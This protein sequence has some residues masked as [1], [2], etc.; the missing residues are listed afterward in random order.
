MSTMRSLDDGKVK[1]AI[2]FADGLEVG[3]LSWVIDSHH[4]FMVLAN[5]GKLIIGQTRGCGPRCEAFQYGTHRVN[6]FNIVNRK[7]YDSPPTIGD[8][9][10]QPLDFELLEGFTDRRVAHTKLLLQPFLP[11]PFPG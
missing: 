7:L 4:C 6:V 5:F 9:F 1:L 8:V 2:Q 10:N 11:Q 3:T